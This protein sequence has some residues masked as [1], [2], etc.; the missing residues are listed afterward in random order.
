MFAVL[1]KDIF[2]IDTHF[3]QSPYTAYSNFIL[4]NRSL[5]YLIG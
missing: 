1:K 3:T 5:F 4:F 2:P